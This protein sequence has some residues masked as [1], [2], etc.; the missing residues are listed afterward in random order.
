MEVEGT[1][2]SGVLIRGATGHLWFLRDDFDQPQRIE[3]AEL[4][5]LVKGYAEEEGREDFVG[6]ELPED[7]LEILNDLF[8]PLIGI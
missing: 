3:H 6:N 5:E 2:H 1:P 4:G 7:V 8:G